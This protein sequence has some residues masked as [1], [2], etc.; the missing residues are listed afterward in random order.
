MGHAVH[1]DP[2]DLL[3]AFRSEGERIAWTVAGRD[4]GV[5][6]PYCADL[7]TGAVVRHLGSIYRRVTG[8]S[9]EQRPPQRYDAFV[10]YHTWVT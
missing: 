10:P 6:V 2:A 9:A 1:V 7:N 8:W 4:L 5:A 3:A